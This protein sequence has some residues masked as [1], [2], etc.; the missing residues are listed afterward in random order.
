MAAPYYILLLDE[1]CSGFLLLLA[2]GS[3]V[4]AFVFASPVGVMVQPYFKKFKKMK[5]ILIYL[6][7]C[8]KFLFQQVVNIAITHISLSNI[9]VNIFS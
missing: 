3:G 5:L 9:I 2:L 6:I 4:F 1:S 8:I 7:Q